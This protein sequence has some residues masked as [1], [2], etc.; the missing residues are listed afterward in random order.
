MNES[1]WRLREVMAQRGMYKTNELIPYLYAEGIQLSRPQV[2]R[3]VTGQPERLNTRI[4]MV[5]CKI[6]ECTPNDLIVWSDASDQTLRTVE[7]RRAAGADTRSVMPKP[8]RIVKR[9]P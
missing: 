8:A 2:Y 9:D 1:W 4:L 3:L 5:L 7:P 6:L